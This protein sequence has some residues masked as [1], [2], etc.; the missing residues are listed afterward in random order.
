MYEKNIEEAST[1]ST[2]E[3]EEVITSATT[4]E[5]EL[6]LEAVDHSGKGQ[7]VLID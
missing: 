2:T 5:N 1:S 6:G 7:S 4:K 3:G